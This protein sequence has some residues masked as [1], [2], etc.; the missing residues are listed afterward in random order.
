MNW[1]QR[2]LHELF[3]WSRS[4]SERRHRKV[5]YQLLSETLDTKSLPSPM[6]FGAVAPIASHHENGRSLHGPAEVHHVKA[7]HATKNTSTSS[8]GVRVIDH[9]HNL[10]AH[11]AAPKITMSSTGSGKVDPR[12][13]G[14]VELAETSNSGKVDPRD[15]EGVELVRTATSGKVDPRDNEGVE[16]GWVDQAVVERL[17]KS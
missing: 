17:G 10:G 14:G 12:D 3:G 11:S 1:V 4:R 15:N 6:G 2:L 5:E 13:D 9:S 16:L 7:V 8:A